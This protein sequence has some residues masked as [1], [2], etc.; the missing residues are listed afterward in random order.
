MIRREFVVDGNEFFVQFQG[1]IIQYWNDQGEVNAI[2]RFDEYK[3]TVNDLYKRT[4][5]SEFDCQNAHEMPLKIMVL[6]NWFSTMRKA[7]INEELFRQ[8][9][10]E[11]LPMSSVQKSSTPTISFYTIS[12]RCSCGQYRLKY[13]FFA[14]NK[15]LDCKK[16]LPIWWEEW[17][18]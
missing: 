18:I 11:Y 16:D 17:K 6:V 12:E 2:E 10:D 3:R 1:G 8:C 4:G 9:L 5:L 15:C 14:Y 7:E 13:N